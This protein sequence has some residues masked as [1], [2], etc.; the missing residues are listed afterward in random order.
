MRSGPPGRVADHNADELPSPSRLCL[1]GGTETSLGWEGC[2]RRAWHFMT[3]WA[4]IGAACFDPTAASQSGTLTLG[5]TSADQLA[6]TVQPHRAVARQIIT[7]AVQVTALDPLGNTDVSFTGQ[8]TVSLGTNPGGGFLGGTLTVG[9][10]NGVAGPTVQRNPGVGDS[11][12]CPRGSGTGFPFTSKTTS[13]ADSL[14]IRYQAPRR[15]ADFTFTFMRAH[16]KAGIVAPRA[17]R[18]RIR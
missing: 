8:V 10:V 6:F 14:R 16:W 7:P 1:R 15:S 12:N 9:A 4:L 13:L 3:V 2:M 17:L 18:W 5:G 11:C